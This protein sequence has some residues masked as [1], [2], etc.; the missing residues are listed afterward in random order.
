MYVAAGTIDAV[1]RGAVPGCMAAQVAVELAAGIAAC[2]ACGV[3]VGHSGT[4]RVSTCVDDAIPAGRILCT[5]AV[6]TWCVKQDCQCLLWSQLS[7]CNM[8]PY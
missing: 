2:T 7:N 4:I 5:R 3:A 8:I 1:F 6:Q